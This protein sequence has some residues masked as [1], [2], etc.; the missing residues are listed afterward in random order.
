MSS[1]QNCS[2]RRNFPI[3][4]SGEGRCG[5]VEMVKGSQATRCGQYICIW[6]VATKP[7]KLLYEHIPR[8]VSTLSLLVVRIES[9]GDISNVREQCVKIFTVVCGDASQPSPGQLTRQ[10]K[11]LANSNCNSGP[12]SVAARFIA[13]DRA[14][15]H[16][17]GTAQLT[18]RVVSV[19]L[20]NEPARG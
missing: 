11:G 5:A 2:H 16:R 3:V 9:E 19:V 12:V 10:Y 14:D 1:T 18:K 6:M 13:A 15:G 17:N 7:L 8:C 20:L 4:V